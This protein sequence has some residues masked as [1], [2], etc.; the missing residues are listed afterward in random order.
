MGREA[1]QEQE[2]GLDCRLSE[3]GALFTRGSMPRGGVGVGGRCGRGSHLEVSF[4][5]ADWVSRHRGQGRGG[6]L[7]TA[8]TWT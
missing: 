4:S 7:G 1:S 6:G 2:C 3:P 8:S 5:P